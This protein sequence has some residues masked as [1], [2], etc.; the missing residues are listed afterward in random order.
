MKKSVV[1]R[2]KLLYSRTYFSTFFF[3]TDCVIVDP[4]SV[5]IENES[6]L[7][8]TPDLDDCVQIKV[9]GQERKSKMSFTLQKVRFYIE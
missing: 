7:D 1:H 5:P 3:L 2:M 9:Q 8:I 6:L 4:S